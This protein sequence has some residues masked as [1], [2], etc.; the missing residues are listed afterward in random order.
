MTK[1]EAIQYLEA[2]RY[3]F[4]ISLPEQGDYEDNSMIAR[5]T[6]E[7]EEDNLNCIKALDMAIEAL[8][9]KR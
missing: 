4:E 3:Q 9:R 6:V 2:I 8:Q 1:S 5:E 7:A